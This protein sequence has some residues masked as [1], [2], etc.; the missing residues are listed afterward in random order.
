MKLRSSLGLLILTC[1]S[2]Q[3][4]SQTEDPQAIA[5]KLQESKKGVIEAEAQKR[6]ILGSLYVINQKMK[7][8]SNDKGHLTNE[9]FQVQDNVK[10]LAKVI[11]GLELQIDNQRKQ[12][13]H[14]LR[15]LYKISGQGYIGMVFSSTS[16]NEFDETLRF[17][18]IVT[19]NDYSLI[20]NF[21]SN[22][23]V[24]KVKKNKLRGQIEKLVGIEKNI[25]KQESLLATEHHAKSKIVSQLDKIKIENMV[26]I[27][28]LRFKGE[29]ISGALESKSNSDSFAHVSS[30]AS[31]NIG[32]NSNTILSDLLKPS[33]YEQKGQLSAPIQGV[34]IQDF[35]LI[36]DEKY[37]IQLAHKGWRYSATP[38]TTV[39]S[40]FDG[41]VVFAD[42]IPGYGL[43]AIVDHGDHY[44]SVYSQITNLKFSA[45]SSI[46]KGD[47]I[48]EVGAPK[49]GSISGIYFEIRHFSEPENPANWI[50]K[51][52]FRQA[53]N[54]GT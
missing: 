5:E 15:A 32:A 30:G 17:L 47:V 38:G 42:S 11:A 24:Y 54:L 48:A 33:I 37:K 27:K 51:K 49:K 12:L 25:K 20:Q 34:V 44:Y 26:R 3:A 13:R 23:A 10:N 6:R 45:G 9:L 50:T 21:Q 4:I 40:V 35:G 28:N 53:S 16:A 36:T 43:T 7:K 8:I 1:V 19:D 22:L 14:R 39:S 52:Q 41:T 2:L 46:K 18:K 31:T 29:K